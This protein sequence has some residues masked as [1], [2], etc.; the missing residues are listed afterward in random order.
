MARLLVGILLVLVFAFAILQPAFTIGEWEQGIILQFGQW[1]RTLREP[2][3]YLKIP[4]IQ[5][6]I[7]FDKRVLTSDARVAEY[8]TLDK[9]RVLI[10][11]VSRWRIDQP[12]EFYRTVREPTQ[13]RTRLDAVISARLRQE[14]AKHNFLDLIRENRE[15]IME[16]VTK[17]TIETS[18][19]FGIEVLDVRVK[20]LDLPKEVQESV[21]ERMKAERQRIAKRY[22]AEG[23]EKAQEIRAGAEREREVILATAYETSEK[24]KGEGDAQATEIYANAFGQDEEFYAFTRRLQT[25]EKILSTDTTL[26]LPANS[27]LLNYLQSPGRD[28]DQNNEAS[29]D[30]SAVQDRDAEP[31]AAAPPPAVSQAEAPVEPVTAA[32]E[33]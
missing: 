9:K 6:L 16:I 31:V 29:N 27:E 5:T 3:L 19:S 15:D 7:R 12:L 11:H 2:G 24:L 23:E 4:G 33:G 1:Q 8:L 10:D 18:K 17:D 25:Y 28:Y 21:F 14:I 26:V 22:R 13:A 32:K 30:T 20:R